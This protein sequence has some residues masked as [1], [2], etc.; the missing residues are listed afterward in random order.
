M[1][2][3]SIGLVVAASVA[4]VAVVS[5]AWLGN[6]LIESRATVKD[7]QATVSKLDKARKT[8]DAA[9]ILRDNLHQE[10][11]E[12]ARQELQAIE[13]IPQDLPDS[14]YLDA[15]RRSIGLLPEATG[16]ADNPAAKPA[17]G[18]PAANTTGETPAN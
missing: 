4:A 18:L 2:A 6:E 16:G 15:L 17:G 12:D 14:D 7:L 9:I 13:S 1:D 3:K 5:A 11:K 8:D 10:A